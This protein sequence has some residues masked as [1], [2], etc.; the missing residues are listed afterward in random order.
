MLD[1]KKCLADC[2]E[3]ME[4]SVMHLEDTLAQIRAGKANVHILDE[5]K[6][7]WMARMGDDCLFISARERLHIE[8]LKQLLYTRVKQLHVQKYPYNDF[9]FDYYEE[10]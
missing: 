4:M 7:T 8:E 3:K 10:Q 9:L 5:L 2:E 6:N 1:V